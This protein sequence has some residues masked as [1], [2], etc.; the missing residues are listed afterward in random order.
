L[1]RPRR[2]ARLRIAEVREKFRREGMLEA[3]LITE[4]GKKG[5][6][7]LGMINRWDLIEE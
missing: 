1:R 3:A 5:E 4:S 6:K 2:W 7:L